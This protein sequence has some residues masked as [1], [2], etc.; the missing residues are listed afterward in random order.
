MAKESSTLKDVTL[1]ALGAAVGA[2]LGILLAP[3]AGKETREDV[4]EWLKV[5][6]E[7]VLAKVRPENGAEET[8]ETA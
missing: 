2:A 3:K 4:S 6:R 1:F 5:K 8:V 7:E